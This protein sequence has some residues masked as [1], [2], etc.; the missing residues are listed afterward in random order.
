MKTF[1]SYLTESKNTH[2]THLEDQM[3]DE[4]S[5][6]LLTAVHFIGSLVRMLSSSSKSTVRVTTKWDGA[7]AIVCG[8][9]PSNGKFFVGTKSV[10]NSQNPKINYSLSDIDKNH[11]GELAN[12]LKVAFTNLKTLGIKEVLQGDLLFTNTDLKVQEIDGQSCVTFRPNTITYAVP[13]NTELANRISNSKIGV[14]FHTKYTGSSL[15]TSSA[16]FDVNISK[17]KSNKNAWIIDAYF[18]DV[19][20]TATFTA[21]ETLQI[22]AKIKNI[23]TL[24]GGKSKLLLNQLASTNL[25]PYMHMYFNAKIRKGESL[26]S[27]QE[28]VDGLITFIKS[29]F[30]AEIEKLKT[31]KGKSGKAEAL[32]NLI[33]FIEQSRQEL[34]N[35]Y[36]IQKLIIEC[37]LMIVSKLQKIKTIG[38]FIKTENGFRVTSPEGF[39]AVSSTDTALKL[40]DRLE[41]SKD[42]FTVA[43]DWS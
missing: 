24:L 30:H 2:L 7:P 1:R 27:V 31:E 5:L 25:L 3:F 33:N 23:R 28:H 14:V 15:A 42:N 6:G 39:V 19:S 10:F 29:K 18:K 37:K 35:L 8:T 36:T 32:N 41:F 26:E 13:V 43:K 16:S 21:N 22:I 20:G 38:T 9:D 11:D 4:G 17:L 12:K 34:Y 40:V